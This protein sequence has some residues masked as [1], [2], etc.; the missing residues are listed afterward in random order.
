MEAFSFFSD[1]AEDVDFVDSTWK[2]QV[3]WVMFPSGET[4]INEQNIRAAGITMFDSGSN[5]EVWNQILYL[6]LPG[7]ELH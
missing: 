7:L 1:F 5:L 6:D 4:T 3:V 2:A